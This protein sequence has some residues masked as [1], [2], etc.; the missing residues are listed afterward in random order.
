MQPVTIRDVAR[1]AGVSSATASRVLSGNPA[2][3]EASRDRVTAAAAELGFSPNAQARS[4]RS[5]RTDSIALLISDV[6]NPYFADLAHAVEQAARNRGLVTFIGNANEDPAQQDEFL[7]A[8]MSRRVDGVLLVPQGL[9]SDGGTRPSPAVEHLLTR[10]IP[11][12]LVD[13]TLAG[14][15]APHVTA[16]ST[17]ALHDAVARLA[18]D[19]H[20]RI[21]F[22]G[23]PE[24]TSTAAERYADFRAALAA[25]GLDA[26]DDLHFHG[27]FRTPSGAEG[28]RW[29]LGLEERPT[30][31]VI[32][33]SPM[34][35][36][37][38][39]VW[40]E[41]GLAAGTDL[42]VIAF[43]D[44]E[45]FALHDPPLATISHDLT[46]MGRRAVDT[47]ADLMAGQPAASTVLR[48]TFTDRASIG[49]A[50]ERN[51]A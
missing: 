2:T 9:D 4:L 15:A 33:D 19:G 16:S 40:R 45:A 49:P 39:A 28:A 37:A 32:A 5:T 43:D 36:G 23:G 18:R 12:V 46:D 38:L 27:D 7:D 35:I 24:H 22:I 30:A 10:D 50:A 44:I 3:S 21:A 41:A 14:V 29:L 51:P 20:R 31:V 42:S 17:A 47:L 6:R 8:M 34:A 48:S 25:H 26:G 13:R 1:A 11:T